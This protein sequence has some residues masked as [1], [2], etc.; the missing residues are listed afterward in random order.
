MLKN[1][2]S[3]YN[4]KFV[5]FRYFNVAGADPLLKLGVAPTET[6]LIPLVLDVASS[7]RSDITVFGTDYDTED[8][9]R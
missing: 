2:A 9:T 5:I 1:F 6:H 4:L 8:G 7:K 3:T